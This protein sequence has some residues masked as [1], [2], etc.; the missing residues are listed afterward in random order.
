M[1]GYFWEVKFT[2]EVDDGE[3]PYD[4]TE[5][6]L[7]FASIE[8]CMAFILSRDLDVNKV[9]FIRRALGIWRRPV[10]LNDPDKRKADV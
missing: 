5:D 10:L 7:F 3:Y 9:E 6:S 2:H 1:D 8:E 4:K